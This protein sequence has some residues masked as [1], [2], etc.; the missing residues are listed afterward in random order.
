VK[1]LPSETQ[2]VTAK[3]RN[4]AIELLARFF[5]ESR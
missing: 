3:T 4:A 1:L 5:R 2:V